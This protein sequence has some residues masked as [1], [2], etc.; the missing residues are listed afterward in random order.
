M[1]CDHCKKHEAVVHITKIEN[2]RRTDIHL[3]ADCAG[4]Q[5]PFGSDG[6]SNIVDND[7]F[8]KMAYPDHHGRYGEELR[9]NSCGTTYEEFNR[10]GKFGCPDCYE[11]FE[12]EATPLLRRIHGHGRH[13]GK[14]P[15]RGSGVFR[16][17]TQL[18]R[19]RQHL[20]KLIAA[21]AYEDAATVRDEIRALEQ[22]RGGKEG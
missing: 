19:L 2:G 15:E 4:K 12:E 10:N 17:E 7:F 11:T 3:C 1:L 14:V 13:V 6:E 5:S 9:C 21:E 8:R 18:K 20:Q 22:Q 16:T